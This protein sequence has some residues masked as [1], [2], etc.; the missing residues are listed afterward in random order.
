MVSES[1]GV[2]L[3]RCLRPAYHFTPATGRA[4]DP[5]GLC[6]YDGLYHLFFLHFWKWPDDTGQS[7]WGHLV[8]EDMIRWREA[9][10]AFFP[11]E[12]Y[13]SQ[14]CWSGCFRMI[15]GIPTIFYSGVGKDGVSACV[16]TGDDMY[17]WSKSDD[18]PLM[19]PPQLRANWG[20]LRLARGRHLPDVDGRKARRRTVRIERPALVEFSAPAV[21][22]RPAAWFNEV[23]LPASVQTG[24]EAC[25]NRLCASDAAEHL[26][27]RAL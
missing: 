10:T 3:P 9:P 6:W 11:G 16:A 5:N 4:G 15:D 18:N 2:E 20:P 7:S 8:S 27:R 13:D 22:G 14:S 17:R 12:A 24:R 26:F 1:E 25:V 19:T 23:G 21:G